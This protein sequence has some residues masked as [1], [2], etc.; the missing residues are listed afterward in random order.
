MIT[1]ETAS[2][3]HVPLLLSGLS[4]VASG[5]IKNLYPEVSIS[6]VLERSISRAREA[7]AF[8]VDGELVAIVGV[9]VPN[10]LSGEAFP[11]LI[12][13]EV[14]ADKYKF[15]FL[16]LSKRWVKEASKKYPVMQNMVT[17][18]NI[19]ALKW[20]KWLGFKFGPAVQIKGNW[21]RTY[22]MEQ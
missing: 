8:F 7:D 2:S 16:D 1:V 10:L 13:H 5:E 19:R 17:A 9:T 21:Y 18:K 3:K 11:W 6:E 14:N 15:L 22:R 20:L 4:V 12:P